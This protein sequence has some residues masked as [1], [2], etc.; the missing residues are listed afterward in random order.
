MA[1]SSNPL[2]HPGPA[3]RR[4]SRA[5]RRGRGRADRRASTCSTTRR[6]ANGAIGAAQRWWLHH[7][8]AAL[9]RRPRAHG[10]RLLLLRGRAATVLAELAARGRRR[11][12]PRDRTLRAMRQGA[13]STISARALTLTLHAGHTSRPR[14]AVTT[15]QRRP[16]PHLHAVLERAAAAR[17]RPPPPM[18][19]P[20]GPHA[21]SAPAGRPPR[22][23]APA[24]DRTPIG[25]AGAT[26]GRR[27][28]RA[29]TPRST[30]SPRTS[31]AMRK[32]AT[33]P[34][35]TR[36]SRLSPHLHWG[37]I[38][39]AQVWHAAHAAARD[40][41]DPFLREIAWRDFALNLVDQ[42]PDQ[43]RH[44]QPRRASP[45]SRTA[46]RPPN[47]HA[48]QHGRTG[49]P[50]VDAGMRQLW[51]TGWMH[52]RVRMIAASFL[53]KHLLIDWREGERWFWDTLV[54]ADLGN[55]ALGWQWIMGSGVDSPPFFRIFNPSARA[56]S[57]TRRR[58]RPPLGARARAAARRGDPRAMEGRRGDRLRR[59]GVALGETYPHPI[60]DHAARARRARS[61][62]TTRSRPEADHFRPRALRR[63]AGRRLSGRARRDR[64]RRKRA[65]GCGSSSRRSPGSATARWRSAMRSRRSPRRSAYLA[66]PLLGA[67]AARAASP[68]STRCRRRTRRRCSARSMR[69]KLRSSLTLFD[70]AGGGRRS[71]RR[72]TAGSAA[73]RDP[74]T[75][76]RALT[77]LPR[78][79]RRA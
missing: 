72:S 11:R 45:T 60:V 4:P 59:P 67:A 79:A 40:A 74:A 14:G 34:A 36:T 44:A 10:A 17:C 32:A 16:L 27:A 73:T 61:P 1:A 12:G 5:E 50:I 30:P 68:R 54:D 25:R 62:R 7:S 75:L 66:H 51:Q 26:S 24:A 29:R 48:W 52:N 63:G 77:G 6:R 42:F 15:G 18:P 20:T 53:V 3:P 33:C 71:P 69:S 35:T 49:Y 76:A 38:S 56:R 2:V 46:T 31:T 22:R 57:S 47:S 55:N 13:S 19:A 21:P 39:P 9:G 43:R 65:T 41:A 70:A 28:R 37:E 64:A 58:L 23:L 78:A 8:L